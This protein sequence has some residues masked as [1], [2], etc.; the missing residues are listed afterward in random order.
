MS[1][2]FY[3]IPDYTPYQ[4]VPVDERIFDPQKALDPFDKD[5]DWQAAMLDSPPLDG[6]DYT[7]QEREAVRR[8]LQGDGD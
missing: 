8:K 5:F 6:R 4:A 2:S 3:S 7:R 1:D